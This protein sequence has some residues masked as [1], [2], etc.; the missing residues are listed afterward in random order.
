MKSQNWFLVVLTAIAAMVVAEWARGGGFEYRVSV[1]WNPNQEADLGGYRLYWTTPGSTGFVR[2][3][4]LAT[5]QVV[6]LGSRGPW[7]MFVTAYSTQG[8]ESE[9]SSNL[10]I[11]FPPAPSGMR[12]VA[13]T[14]TT[15]TNWILVP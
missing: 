11:T 10:V 5:N 13:G 9:P 4:G 14:V 1:R 8:L 7:T 6:M 3:C 12:L 2:D 15:T